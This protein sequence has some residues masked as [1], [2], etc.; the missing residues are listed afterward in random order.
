MLSQ[1]TICPNCK[2]ADRV[3]SASKAH[4]SVPL[5]PSDTVVKLV[6]IWRW[7]FGS[8]FGLLVLILISSLLLGACSLILAGSQDET[9]LTSLLGGA[10]L[11]PLLCVAPVGSLVGGGILILLPW[12]IG[13][14]VNQNYQKRFTQ[15]QTAINK[16]KK[17]WFCS[18]CAGVWLEGQN[19]IV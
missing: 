5:K 6:K 4:I 16:Y 15:W 7:M 10:M 13:R 11:V 1:V 14:Y 9:G 8:I 18:R 2:Q 12:L 19:R 17:L 3:Q